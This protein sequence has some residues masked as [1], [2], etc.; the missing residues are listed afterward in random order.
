MKIEKTIYFDGA[1]YDLV[2]KNKV[3]VG[4][5]DIKNAL[6]RDLGIDKK[7]RRKGLAT[8]LMKK[9]IEDFGH[10]DLELDVEIDETDECISEI[11]LTNLRKFYRKF[12]FVSDKTCHDLMY[13]RGRE[14][15]HS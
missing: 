2:T 1:R 6:I 3:Y 5:V 13:R 14:T 7:Y 9:V 10:Q 15:A 8:K 11:S 4:R 12:G